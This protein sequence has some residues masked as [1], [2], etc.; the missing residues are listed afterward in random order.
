MDGFVLSKT[1]ER[2]VWLHGSRQERFLKQKVVTV[3][4]S[5]INMI[6]TTVEAG[7]EKDASDEIR[8]V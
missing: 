6:G 1:S 3:A 4:H 5:S 8:I 2:Q 7:N